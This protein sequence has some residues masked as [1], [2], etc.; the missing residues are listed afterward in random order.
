MR[1]RDARVLPP[2]VGLQPTAPPGGGSTG[3]AGRGDALHPQ[4]RSRGGRQTADLKVQARRLRA[5][6][7]P[8]ETRFWSELRGERLGGFRFRRQHQI[9]PYIAD[10]V[11]V[12]ARLV[13]ELLGS[14]HDS[15]EA[16]R[17]DAKR[18]AFLNEAGYKVLELANELV[19]NNIPEARSLVLAALT[20]PVLPPPGG[21]G[22]AAVQAAGRGGQNPGLPHSADPG[23]PHA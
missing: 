2:S 17:K 11:C 10:F 1:A 6:A 8:A 20:P 13:V 5:G 22:P 12:S 16:V 3:V 14:V 19:L 4:R 15:P 23:S 7:T 18:T 21:V 9:G